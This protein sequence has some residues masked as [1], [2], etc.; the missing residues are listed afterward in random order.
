MV[1]RTIIISI[2]ILL[3]IALSSNVG[4]LVVIVVTPAVAEVV[5]D[6]AVVV[7]V[8]LDSISGLGSFS[9]C[10]ALHQQFVQIQKYIFCLG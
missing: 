7:V 9:S 8:V 3:D 4:I 2:N 5:D 1:I 10:T 6:V